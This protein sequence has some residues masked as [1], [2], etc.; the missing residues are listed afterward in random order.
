MD[1]IKERRDRRAGKVTPLACAESL[2]Q[3]AEH[4]RI[5]AFVAVVKLAD[6]TIQTTWSHV[7][8]IEALGLLECGKDDVMQHMRE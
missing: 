4:G 1:E 8:S 5:E 7:Q 6:G 2:L 3:A